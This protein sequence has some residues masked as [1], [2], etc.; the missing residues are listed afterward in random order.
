MKI[1]R[2][3]ITNMVFESVKKIISENLDISG[4]ISNVSPFVLGDA[5]KYTFGEQAKQEVLSGRHPIGAALNLY[6]N[7][8]PEKQK[9]FLDRLLGK[10][11]PDDSIDFE[12]D[13][14]V[15]AL[16]MES[17][18]RAVNNQIKKRLI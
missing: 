9:E 8:S 13:D 3:D 2:K 15:K 12:L 18:E 10:S 16:F 14:D 5:I 11:T 7:A 6:N 17:I 4:I 1:T